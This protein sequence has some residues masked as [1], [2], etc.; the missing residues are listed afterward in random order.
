[1][2]CVI[3]RRTFELSLPILV[4]V[5]LGVA[6]V[7]AQ[8]S[9]TERTAQIKQ[10]SRQ[11]GVKLKQSQVD[12][13]RAASP[14][15]KA[16]IDSARKAM[17]A[18]DP[19]K[20][21]GGK[22]T[23]VVGHTSAIANPE[24][25]RTGFVR[26]P[27]D[28]AK[29]PAQIRN[30]AVSLE[31]ERKIHA[32]LQS[33]AGDGDLNAPG[34]GWGCSPSAAAFDWRAKGAVSPIRD[35][36][37]CGSC[38]AHAAIAA[39]EGSYFITNK[40]SFL[41]SEQQLLD[42]SKGGNCPKGGT[43][44]GAW[45]NLQGYGTADASVYPYKHVQN[46]CQWAKPTPY[47]WA[48]WGWVNEA[49]P[50]GVAPV[51]LL[52]AQLCRRGP[53]ATTIVSETDKFHGYLGGV[54]NELTAADVDHAVTIV[55]WDD[56]KQAWLIKNSWATTWGEK[57]YAWVHYNA[58]RIGTQT[59]WVQARKQVELNDDCNTFAPGDAKVVERGGHMKV[60]AGEHAVADTG[61]NRADAERVVEIVKHYKLSKQCYLGRPDWN[62]EYFLAGSKTPQLELA[63]ESCMRFN[64]G[65]LDVDK[66]GPRWQLKDGIVRIKTFDNEDQAWMAYAY[67]R[68]H[69]FTYR[70]NVGDGFTYWRR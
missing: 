68:R 58:N 18:A 38:W 45:D 1:M 33:H 21:V 23:F 25:R 7:A 31:R 47:H 34:H 48:A 57:G 16:E 46:Q 12:A 62:F 51:E 28:A 24:R 67:L 41:G 55:G 42:C 2:N 36:G 35:Q 5:L 14:T 17:L 9:E 32:T 40:V 63:G 19:A 70:C 50:Y 44:D 39:F 49:D 61:V 53:L 65:G 29:I 59:A 4:G 60:L 26:P 54:I 37:D 56:A 20:F 43:Y 8:V 11:T 66:D 6:P 30:T 69:A 64:L 13:E 15:A 52:K 22:P 27:N 10:L 3:L